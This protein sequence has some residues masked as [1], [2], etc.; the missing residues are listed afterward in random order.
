MA[1]EDARAQDGG[2]RQ[3]DVVVDLLGLDRGC[4]R[5]GG[6]HSAGGARLGRVSLG[7][8]GQEVVV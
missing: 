1:R 2:E 3:S 4:R 7:T 8:Q 5:V 6:A